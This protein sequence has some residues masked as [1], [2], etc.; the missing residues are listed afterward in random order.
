MEAQTT[1]PETTKQNG[2]ANSGIIPAFTPN[3]ELVEAIAEK[4]EEIA[5]FDEF[6]IA[7]HEDYGNAGTRLATIKRA[8][9]DV[10]ELRK[11]ATRP[12]KESAKQIESWF[13]ENA[14][15]LFDLAKE[16]HEKRPAQSDRRHNWCCRASAS[17]GGTEAS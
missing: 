7:D 16:H 4:L 6:Q 8:I 10:T 11:E 1:L 5:I 14:L 3:A 15:D 2:A 12:L 9:T 17:R 13:K